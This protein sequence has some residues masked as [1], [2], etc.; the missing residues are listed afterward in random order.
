MPPVG[1]SSLKRGLKLGHMNPNAGGIGRGVG[2]DLPVG[3]RFQRKGGR[4]IPCRDVGQVS[5]GFFLN[6]VELR[7]SKRAPCHACGLCLA[8]KTMLSH[9][10]GLWRVIELKKGISLSSF[11]PVHLNP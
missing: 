5:C 4:T 9:K 6:H 3:K 2:S 10:Q 7:V 8:P 1:N 11:S